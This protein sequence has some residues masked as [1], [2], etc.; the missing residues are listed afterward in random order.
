MHY[1]MWTEEM[2]EMTIL[3]IRLE[4]YLMEPIV[5]LMMMILIMKSDYITSN[6]KC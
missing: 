6:H 2:L 5:A 3:I 1:L 4:M